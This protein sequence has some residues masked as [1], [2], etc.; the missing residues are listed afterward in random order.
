VHVLIFFDVKWFLAF[1]QILPG[2]PLQISDVIHKTRVDV[3]EE[4]TEAAAVTAVV[5]V[6][7]SAIRRDV[8]RP[9][10]MNCDRPFIFAIALQSPGAPANELGSLLF[11]GTV[12]ASTSPA[13]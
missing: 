12:D 11:L 3:N 4:G 13:N 5:M 2:I 10:V 1:S 8:V 7:K 6:R 9:F